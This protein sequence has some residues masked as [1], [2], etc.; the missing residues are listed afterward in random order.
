MVFD[1]LFEILANQGRDFLDNTSV[2]LKQ[3]M[4]RALLESFA[5][6]PHVPSLAELRAEHTKQVK[7]FIANERFAKGGGDQSLRPLTAR[8]A[9]E[10]RRAGYGAR[11]I[12]V[13]TGKLLAA[14]RRFGVVRYL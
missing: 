8:Y 14:F 2:A 4:Q 9:A 7:L 13:R 12:G 6:F 3:R 1:Q 5:G 11:P 10:K